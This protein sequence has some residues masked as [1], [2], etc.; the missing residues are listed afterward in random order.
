LLMRVAIFFGEQMCPI[1]LLIITF[2]Y[3]SWLKCF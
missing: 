2:A 3:E 1:F